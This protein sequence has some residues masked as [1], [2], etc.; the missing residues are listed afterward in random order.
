MEQFRFSFCLVELYVSFD[1]TNLCLENYTKLLLVLLIHQVNFGHSY[2]LNQIFA[3]WNS[4][5]NPEK[6]TSKPS[7]IVENMSDNTYKR[8]T[9]QGK[10]N[11]VAF[12]CIF[13]V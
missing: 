9:L 13:I 4:K 11:W 1:V 6:E 8:L 10:I 3:V 5:A 2:I 7:N 12:A